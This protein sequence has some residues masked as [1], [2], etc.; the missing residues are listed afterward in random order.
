M[1]TA[2]ATLRVHVSWIRDHPTVLRAVLFLA[3]VALAAIPSSPAAAIS[4]NAGQFQPGE[5]TP[6]D[7]ISAPSV[8]NLDT[9]SDT[10][11]LAEVS[12]TATLR[13]TGDML[14]EAPSTQ[15]DHITS[16][17]QDWESGGW[18]DE[19]AART[20]R[21]ND[22]DNLIGACGPCNASKGASPLGQGARQWWPR[23]WGNR[24]WPFGGPR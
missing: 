6:S 23:A 8:P 16:L 21:V 19:R 12:R 17:K 1:R 7:T 14:G 3:F 13:P 10:G 11:F 22:P 24:W 5:L 15:A 20:A 2:I 18:S 9:T 4:D